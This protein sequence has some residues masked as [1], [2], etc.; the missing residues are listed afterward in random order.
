[1]SIELAMPSN[2]L[3]FCCPLLRLPSVFPCIK[4]FSNGLALSIR[5]PRIGASS[6]TSVLPMN[7][8]GWFPLGLTGLI[9]WWTSD[10]QESSPAAQVKNINFLALCV[11][12]GPTL[13][14]IHDYWKDHSLDYMDFC[15]VMSLLFSILSRFVIALLPRSCRLLI[16]QLQWIE[17]S[18][19]C[20]YAFGEIWS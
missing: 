16:S 2:H 11:L 17:R 8:Q 20:G 9:S 19:K 13:T 18:V 3:I 7:I 14:S 15:K 5:W 4:V 10:S 1:M 6:S 12:Y